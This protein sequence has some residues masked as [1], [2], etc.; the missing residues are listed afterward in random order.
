MPTETLYER[1]AD[2]Y[3][4]RHN[5]PTTE[6]VRALEKI[7]IRK[8]ATGKS[9]DVGCGTGYHLDLLENVI[10]LD[11]SKEMLEKAKVKGKPLIL[12]KGE[13]LPFPGEKFDTVLCLFSV[14]NICDAEKAAKEIRRVLKPGGIAIVSVASVWDHMHMSYWKKLRTNPEKFRTKNFR[15]SGER[16][17]L[18][19]FT[20][21][22]FLSLF[23]GFA[24]LEFDSLFS[25]VRPRWNSFRGFS[26]WE[27]V[28]LKVERIFP[29][30]YG[31]MY[32]GVFKRID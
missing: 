29:K 7:L 20:K 25:V 15:V 16:A 28:L 18:R 9:L 4:I 19:L 5:S 30:G 11:P 23:E 8:Y 13:K 10:G 27:K 26:A 24:L 32:F 2:V 22:D 3:D 6:R 14:L 17:K 1:T 21:K 12:G 31:N